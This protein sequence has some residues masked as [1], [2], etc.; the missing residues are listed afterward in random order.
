M[1]ENTPP[2]DACITGWSGS[3]RC[4][5]AYYCGKQDCCVFCKEDCNIRCGWIDT[6]EEKHN[7]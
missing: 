1:K 6:K 4:G 7:D 5:A 2:K 3:G